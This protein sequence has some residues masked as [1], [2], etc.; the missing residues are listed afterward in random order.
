MSNNTDQ[1]DRGKEMSSEKFNNYNAW[2]RS[3][4]TGDG[5]DR[6]Q[7]NRGYQ[8]Q[9]YNN[10]SYNPNYKYQNNKRKFYNNNNS[11]NGNNQ[12]Q[13]NNKRFNN[14]TEIRFN[15]NAF[16]HPSMLQDPWAKFQ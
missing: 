5:S 6:N 1:N 14:A 3:S 2:C 8:N 4:S 7:S 15:A 16:Y 12:Y 9:S 10:N 11:N 13:G